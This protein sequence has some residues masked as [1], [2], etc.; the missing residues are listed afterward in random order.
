[1][2]YKGFIYLITNKVNGKRYVGQTM[3]REGIK[4][5]WYHHRYYLNRNKHSNK[6]LQDAWNKYG[7]ENFEFEV[8]HE[9]NFSNKDT[10]LE[11]LNDLEVMYISIWHLLD[12]N[13]GYNIA[14]G[15]SN[16]NAFAGK[17]E[18]ELKEWRRKIGEAN[19]GKTIG[20]KNA[21]YGKRG[22]NSPH[23]GKHHSEDTKKHQS[24]T[25]KAK[26]KSGEIIPAMKG[27]HHSDETKKKMSESLK[28]RPSNM[29]G[30]KHS[31]ESK[32]K[33]SESMKGKK[34][35]NM[36]GENHPFYGKN[37][38]EETKRKISETLKGKKHT[39]ETKKKLS[40]QRKG[41]HI[42]GN[43]P[44]AKKVKCI[45]TGQIFGSVKDAEEKYHPK[46]NRNA[47]NIYNCCKG[48]QSTAYKLHWEYVKEGDVA[49]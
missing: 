31:E 16:G 40:E 45:E 25:M 21:M 39:E 19:K 20:E 18:E 49:C 4:V 8:L 11:A 9:L 17:S 35:P 28:G 22:E 13:Y 30:K 14:S 24:E 23:W 10:L 42:G 2:K 46:H 6:H 32:K 44:N 48:N 27:K 38:P 36:C 29:K 41:K 47:T 37:L 43:N 1:M 26:Y 5:R 34:R 12:V 15:G 33:I 7:E 3:N